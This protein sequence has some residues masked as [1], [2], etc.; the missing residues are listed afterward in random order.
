MP[1]VREDFPGDKEA[2]SIVGQ[3]C[4]SAMVTGGSADQKDIRAQTEWDR[5]NVCWTLQVSELV[6]LLGK[7]STCVH[8]SSETGRLRG[9]AGQSALDADGG[10]CLFIF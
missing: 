6:H 10:E 9:Q 3:A 2:V 4:W 5:A 8:D 7:D 1:F